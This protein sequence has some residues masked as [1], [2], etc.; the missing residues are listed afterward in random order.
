MRTRVLV[1]TFLIPLVLITVGSAL[2]EEPEVNAEDFVGARI[3]VFREGNFKERDVAEDELAGR[4]ESI[5]DAL[6]AFAEDADAEVSN[7]VGRALF[8]IEYG[9]TRECLEVIGGLMDDYESLSRY[10]RKVRLIEVHGL[11]KEHADLLLLNRSTK[12]EF[13]IVRLY[14]HSLFVEFLGAARMAE[15]EIAAGRTADAKRI[16]DGA[17][18]SVVGLSASEYHLLKARIESRLGN[19]DE[20]ARALGLAIG[21]GRLPEIETLEQYA[22]LRDLLSDPKV[23]SSIV[24]NEGLDQ[25]R[26]LDFESA[27]R[28]LEE[29]TSLDP[30][31]DVNWYNLACAYSLLEMPDEAIATLEKSFE[32]GFED[33]EWAATGDPDFANVRDDIRFIRLINRVRRE[34]RES[35]RDTE[36]KSRA[37]TW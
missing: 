25:L 15:R 13:E 28:S 16:V 31:N 37:Q 9:L 34:I 23:R 7:R 20:A 21:L 14:A 10:R 3:A 35:A 26:Q 19:K 11:A 33:V 18:A 24:G 1:S 12:D 29:A 27:R 6:T 5:L 22:E 8:R 17:L 36:E 32:T 30:E 2:A 4:G